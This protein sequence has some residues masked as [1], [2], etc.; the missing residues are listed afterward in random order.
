MTELDLPT[1]K[2]ILAKKVASLQVLASRLPL[3]HRCA[4]CRAPAGTAFLPEARQIIHTFEA[5]A[6]SEVGSSLR[7][8]RTATVPFANWLNSARG[9]EFLGDLPAINA[10]AFH[11]SRR[12]ILAIF[13]SNILN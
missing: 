4:H 1:P 7:E 9:G 11:V 2:Q 10:V 6:V 8:R 13:V 5:A 3:S 12:S